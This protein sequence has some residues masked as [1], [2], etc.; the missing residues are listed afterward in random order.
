[1]IKVYVRK[2]SACPIRSTFVRRVLQEALEK[3]GIISDSL[4]YVYF[5]KE[6]EIKKLAAKYLGEL[7]VIHEVL[8][9][10][11]SEVRLPFYYPPSKFIYLGEVVLCYPK[12]VEEA[13]KENCL[14]DDKVRQLLEHAS[15][16]LVGVHHN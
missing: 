6:K 5:V 12:I 4:V 13:K 3:K 2:Q 15:L 11:E 16:H 8:T 9:F 1:M 7:D 10:T 14:I